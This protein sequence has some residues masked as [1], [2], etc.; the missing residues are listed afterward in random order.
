MD[1][2][3]PE[4]KDITNKVEE[5]NDIENAGAPKN[6]NLFTCG[7]CYEEYDASSPEFQ[8]KMLNSCEHTF[9]AE[10]FTEYFRSLVEDQNKHHLLICPEAGCG[11]K[12]SEEE[13]KQ[14]LQEDCFKKFKRFQND[15]RVA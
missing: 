4:E 9:C 5:Q 3:L 14:I 13:I 12:A 2:F 10:C 6:Y 8:V 11:V 7:I 1:P 15:R